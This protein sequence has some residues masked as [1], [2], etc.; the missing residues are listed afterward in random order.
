MRTGR[1]TDSGIQALAISPHLI[2]GLVKGLDMEK[3]FQRKAISTRTRFEVFK[4][5]EF[6]CQYCGATPPKVIL[7]VDHIIPV[8]DGGKNK[9]DNFVT[10]CQSC[11]L[12]K[13]NISL[14]SIP[15]SLKD[16]AMEI[17]ER[18]KQILG[19]QK[20]MQAKYDRI[21]Y[22]SWR[23][24]DALIPDSS[25]H[26]FNIKNRQSIVFF[27][28]KIGFFEVLEAAEIAYSKYSYNEKKCFLYFCG[29]CW[30]KIK[31]EADGQ[32]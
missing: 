11:N 19:Y 1:H 21:E 16:K 8:S 14:N 24:C 26:G 6:T 29:I 9:M 32:S 31:G 22:E 20:I 15:Q 17:A 23:I 28:N 12:G 3:S 2:N 7:H 30:N 18:E 13:S 10:S 5:D 27:I 4:R 25:L